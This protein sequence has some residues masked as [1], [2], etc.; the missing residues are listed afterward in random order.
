MLLAL[1]VIC[2]LRFGLLIVEFGLLGNVCVVFC[3]WVVLCFTLGLLQFVFDCVC[4]G[5]CLSDVLVVL[6]FLL[7]G[8]FAVWCD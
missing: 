8:F 1:L 3:W 4:L 2:W 5:L 7:V 6:H